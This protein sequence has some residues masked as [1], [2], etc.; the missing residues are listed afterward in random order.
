MISQ[1]DLTITI[2]SWNTR[3]LL[4]GCLQS[5]QQSNT[6]AHLEIHVVD[7]ASKDGSAEIVCAEFP[8]VKLIVNQENL[9]FAAAN[10]QSWKQARGRYWLLLNSDAEVKPRALDTLVAFMDTHLQAGLATAK[11]LN[12]DSSP[13][14]CAQPVPS[15]WRLVLETSRA[16]KLL[17]ASWRGRVL[18]ST[19][20]NYQATIPVGWTW[21]TA[22]IARKEAVEAV[23]ALSEDFFMYGEDLEWCL[24]MQRHGWK[25]WFCHNAQV[26]HYGGQS[27]AKKWEDARKQKIILDNSYTAIEIHRGRLYVALLKTSTLLALKTDQ[28]IKRLT[29]RKSS[30]SEW[31]INYHKAA[32][33]L[34]LAT[35]GQKWNR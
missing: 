31:S 2:V 33:K 23:G 16:H 29:G 27:S 18:L 35:L 19:Y 21:G 12:P 25:V 34:G 32:L 24:R 8:S 28:I 4:R 30:N 5:I 1:P 26:L 10:N 20:W 14:Y 13:Q 22:L 11:L 17:P 7:N 15:I 6:R 9:G 3:E